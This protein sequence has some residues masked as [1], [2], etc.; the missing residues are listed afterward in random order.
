MGNGFHSFGIVAH[1]VDDFFQITTAHPE[2][3]A[4][5]ISFLPLHT[6]FRC[7]F[8]GGFPHQPGTQGEYCR[9]LG[10]RAASRDVI[11]VTGRDRM[12]KGNRQATLGNVCTNQGACRQ[13]NALAGHG[14]RH[15]KRRIL[16]IGAAQLILDSANT[17]Q[18]EPPP[19]LGG[20]RDR[21]AAS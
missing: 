7:P 18:V 11:G 17:G 5:G 20:R 14:R 21:E 15:S 13:N 2:E 8:P 3:V 16:E 1:W 4:T 6:C 9:T 12:R 19:I 10:L